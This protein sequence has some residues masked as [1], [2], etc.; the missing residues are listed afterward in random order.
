MSQEQATQKL[1]LC[2]SLMEQAVLTVQIRKHQTYSVWM[3][4]GYSLGEDETIS[5]PYI[6]RRYEG[7]EGNVLQVDGVTATV[8]S[9]VN[10]SYGTNN[11][12]YLDAL[13]QQK[14]KKF[15][16]CGQRSENERFW[17]LFGSHKQ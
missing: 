15:D 17:L 11:A 7:N 3:K 8:S 13:Y 9:E 2:R 14:T 6:V 1:R 16:F 4:T 10:G 5:G 12:Y